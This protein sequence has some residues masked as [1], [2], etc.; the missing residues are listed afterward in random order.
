MGALTADRATAERLG[1]EFSYPVAAAVICRAGGIAALDASGNVKPAVTAT[2][3]VCVGR[4]EEMVDNS[5]GGAAAVSAK[6]KRGCFRY[7]NSAAADAITK[8][9]IGDVCYL[10]DDQTVAKTSGS[11]TRS[12]AGVIADVD[13]AGVWV[14]MGYEALTSPAGGLLAANN[15]SDLAT[16]ATARA[17]LGGG[18]DKIIV[19]MGAVSL[20]GADATVLRTVAPVAGDIKAIRS[21]TNGAL[22]TGDATLTGKIGATAI[23]DGVVTIAQAGSAAGDVDAAAPSAAKTVAVGDVISVTVGG[24][25]DAAVTANVVIEITP[26]A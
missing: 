10:V 13:S 6:V 26:S 14:K 5:A 4:F 20:V 15:L 12:V 8:A 1:D 7:A 3:L 11:A 19:S 25:N 2:G 21:V 16:K 22:T 23:T 24:T 17:N 18:A 9:E